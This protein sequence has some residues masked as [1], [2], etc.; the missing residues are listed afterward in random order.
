M[1]IEIKPEQFNKLMELVILGRYMIASTQSKDAAE[2]RE[3][4]SHF[5]KQEGQLDELAYFYKQKNITKRIE[6]YDRETIERELPTVLA[7]IKLGLN[8]KDDFKDDE[9]TQGKIA[10]AAMVI[11]DEML[12]EDISKPDFSFIKFDIENFDK[13]V[14]ENL[15]QFE[16][17]ERLGR[18]FIGKNNF[19]C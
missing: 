18:E 11:M 2:Y 12:K 6:A 19:S 14:A 13:R 16:E 3:L 10:S 8:P 1:K 9:K 17:I 4:V 15:P 7:K 5:L